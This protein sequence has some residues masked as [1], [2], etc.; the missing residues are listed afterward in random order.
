MK[1]GW[2]RSPI[3]PTH[4]A[5]RERDDVIYLFPCEVF[6][7]VS[8]RLSLYKR[9][10]LPLSFQFPLSLFHTYQYKPCYCVKWSIGRIWHFDYLLWKKKCHGLNYS[11][12]TR[13]TIL[14][15]RNGLSIAEGQRCSIQWKLMVIMA[16]IAI[17]QIERLAFQPFPALLAIYMMVL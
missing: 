11:F 17:L 4:T 7:V 1:Y 5:E 10:P 12:E 9:T 15:N 8:Q 14:Y 6:P 3:P 13:R 16:I 2:R